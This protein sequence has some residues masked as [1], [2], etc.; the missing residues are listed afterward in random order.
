MGSHDKF[1]TYHAG[2][3]P[4]KKNYIY[5]VV[6]FELDF[7]MWP[8]PWCF[9]S[10]PFGA[11]AGTVWTTF[12]LIKLGSSS[13]LYTPV[14]VLAPRRSVIWKN[15]ILETTF[16]QWGYI[17]NL[18]IYIWTNHEEQKIIYTYIQF[19][20][21]CMASKA[22]RTSSSTGL[23]RDGSNATSSSEEMS[24]TP[25]SCTKIIVKIH[26]EKVFPN[27]KTANVSPNVPTLLTCYK[28][29]K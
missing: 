28:K 1:N 16:G 23:F 20:L 19:R 9:S 3:L 17:R 4:V 24:N 22:F 29:I 12:L 18:C 10:V 26:V 13:R 15:T 21:C 2:N 14:L 5:I 25:R 11:S 27:P 6:P 7:G 8:P